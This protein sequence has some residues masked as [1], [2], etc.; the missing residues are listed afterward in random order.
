[1]R[2]SHFLFAVLVFSFSSG[3]QSMT[4]GLSCLKDP[5]SGKKRVIIYDHHVNLSVDGAY[6]QERAQAHA[7]QI[8]IFLQEL[9]ERAAKVSYHIELSHWTER[10]IQEGRGPDFNTPLNVAVK[11]ALENQ[12]RLKNITFIP[13]DVRKD[14]DFWIRE[15]ALNKDQFLMA[16]KTHFPLPEDS[17][18]TVHSYVA[19]MENRRKAVE[20]LENKLPASLINQIKEKNEQSYIRLKE[21]IE[22]ICAHQKID[23]AQ[24]ILNILLMNT[25]E[26]YAH[27]VGEQCSH[28]DVTLINN[29]LEDENDLSIVHGGSYHCEQLDQAL[30][31]VGFVDAFPEQDLKNGLKAT[32]LFDLRIPQEVPIN[33]LA[34]IRA[35]LAHA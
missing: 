11:C 34:I 35:F 31:A 32:S 25:D 15:M 4:V 19:H 2:L 14:I 10:M 3:I 21:Y 16:L 6:D 23:H 13:F 20:L 27:F 18:I 8:R 9:I 26:C 30:K 1:M 7:N 24:H 33:F 12:K 5:R 17:F 29:V 22:A 28:V